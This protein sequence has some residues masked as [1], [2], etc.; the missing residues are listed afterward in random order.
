MPFGY[1]TSLVGQALKWVVPD[2]GDNFLNLEDAERNKERANGGPQVEDYAWVR[3]L[4]TLPEDLD[5]IHR[6]L[7]EARVGVPSSEDSQFLWT[8]VMSLLVTDQFNIL[9]GRSCSLVHARTANRIH[10]RAIWTELDFDILRSQCS[11]VRGEWSA[12]YDVPGRVWTNLLSA[13]ARD[14]H[15]IYYGVKSRRSVNRALLRVAIQQLEA[16]RLTDRHQQVVTLMAQLN[17]HKVLAWESAS[18]TLIDEISRRFGLG[19]YHTGSPESSEGSGSTSYWRSLYDQGDAATET[20]GRRD[21]RAASTILTQVSE[22]HQEARVEGENDVLS[23][24]TKHVGPTLAQELAIALQ[25][26][27]GMGQV[28]EPTEEGPVDR[29]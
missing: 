8:A 7:M 22:R 5:P 19:D 26:R 28:L 21:S 3:N 4:H 24:V 6:E 14:D 16:D 9:C 2:L 25:L 1:L 23:Q 13:H 11:H 15:L 29:T 10:G 17:T 20:P 12:E 27:R 18:A